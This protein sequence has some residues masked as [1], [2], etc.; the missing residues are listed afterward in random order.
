MLCYAALCYATLCYDML[1]YAM[2]FFCLRF[3]HVVCLCLCFCLAPRE[4]NWGNRA[5]AFTFAAVSACLP[6]DCPG[7]FALPGPFKPN[8]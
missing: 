7:R 3:C 4:R 8:E 2:L 5:F 1:C 6:G